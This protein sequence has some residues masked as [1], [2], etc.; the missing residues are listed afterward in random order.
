MIGI[1][2]AE[3]VQTA[4]VQAKQ[5]PKMILLGSEHPLHAISARSAR[6]RCCF[7]ISTLFRWQCCA[8]VS[9]ETP[10]S[11]VQRLFV[12]SRS[13]ARRLHAQRRH[14]PRLLSS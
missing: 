12:L 10:E 6:F 11:G 9:A 1:E 7:P 5:K 14:R 13:V 4:Q 2:F 8:L 3:F